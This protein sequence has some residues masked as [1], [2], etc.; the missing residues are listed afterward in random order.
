M[1]HKIAL[2]QAEKEFGAQSQ[3]MITAIEA[4]VHCGFCLPTCPTYQVLGEE[5]DSPRGRIILMKNSLE[6]RFPI[7]EALPFIDRCLGCMAC[8]TA[9]P[10]GVQYGNLLFPF[11][12]HARQLSDGKFPPGVQKTT[13]DLVSRIF[14][15]PDR[16]RKAA[17]FGLLTRPLS[18]LL[19]GK[20]RNMLDLLPDKLPSPI[21]L[22]EFSP[23]RGRRRARVAL[24]TGCVQQALDPEINLATLRVLNE[25]GIE[26]FIVREQV[27]C[28]AILTHSGDMDGA[29]KLA[30]QNIKAFNKVIAGEYDALL[31][32]AAGCGSGI[33]EYP[34]L[35][36]GREEE[37]AAHTLAKKTRDVSLFL[38]E[39]GLV[40]PPALRH[41]LRV[42]YHDACHL[43]H[44]QSVS[45]APRQLLQA[46]P[47]VT[48]LPLAQSEICCGSAGT[49]NL[50]Q[51]LIAR[52]LG[53]QKVE[54]ILAT[55]CDLVVTGNIGCIMQIGHHLHEQEQPIP[56][57]H[58]F[59]LLD[60]AYQNRPA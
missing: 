21:N 18:A 2:D 25:N 5:M 41:P 16:F 23:A 30:R 17:Q 35:F 59:Q 37:Q 42:V 38:F 50:D 4:C 53:R 46:I 6:N 57:L 20:L 10:S 36:A 47:G 32:N 15:Y 14:P 22:P 12:S 11:R 27:C 51:P 40:Q 3:E 54:N 28:G 49:Y 48:L 44:A 55:G 7:Q 52:A 34:L 60:I 1:Q 13:R 33:R 26:V 45:L 43:L 39:L 8:V 29:R 56:V 24:L 19:P 58:T 9:C 31:T